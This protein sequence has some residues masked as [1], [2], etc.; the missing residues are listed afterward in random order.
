M[1]LITESPSDLS[2]CVATI[3]CFDGVHRGHRYLIDQVCEEA[4]NEGL[5]SALITFPLPPRSVIHPEVPPRLLSCL[6]QKIDLLEQTAADYCIL[7]PF[8]VELSRLSARQFMQLLHERYHIQT[9]LIGYDHRFGHNRSEGFEDYCRYGDELGMKIL[10]ARALEERG[11]SISSSLIR[12]L[13]SEG[14]V[15][16]ANH[17]LGYHYYL[18]GTVVDGYKVGRTIGFPT[19]N[20]LPSCA[21]KLIPAHGVYAIYAD[22]DGNRYPGMLNIGC[23]PTVDNGTNIS[24]E[25]HLLDF[26][27]NI[28]HHQIRISFEQYI[29]PE[30]KFAGLDALV[31]QLNL[32]KER[33]RH[34]LSPV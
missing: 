34:L 14:D 5:C 16:Q 11:C 15:A 18:D 7:L 33:V 8:T 31:A 2:P 25:A 28:Y 12:S 32:D 6:Q 17:Y 9:L 21:E 3:G 22:V 29:R 20:L 4:R 13:L 24:I 30:Q 26:T 1:R 19:A 27:G 10:R 23:R